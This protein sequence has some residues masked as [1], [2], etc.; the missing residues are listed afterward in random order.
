MFE[1][2]D[3]ETDRLSERHPCS[4]SRGAE[5]HRGVAVF[6]LHC[7]FCRSFRSRCEIKGHASEGGEE[8]ETAAEKAEPWAPNSDK[9]IKNGD[10]GLG[11]VR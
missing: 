6:P 4:S 2:A 7:G 5:D 1:L 11:L 8:E 9:A 3:R 10:S